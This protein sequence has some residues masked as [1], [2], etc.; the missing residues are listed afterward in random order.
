MIR[1]QFVSPATEYFHYSQYSILGQG[2]T[3]E[4]GNRN[5]WELSSDRVEHVELNGA[6]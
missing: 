4:T 3:M 5:F 6:T 1:F 2:H